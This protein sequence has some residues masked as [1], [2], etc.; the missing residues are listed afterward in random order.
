VAWH[1]H[2]CTIYDGNGQSQLTPL[3]LL[4]ILLQIGIEN[5][6]HNAGVEAQ[7]L[8]TLQ[9]LLIVRLLRL[10]AVLSAASRLIFF[11]FLDDSLR[12]VNSSTIDINFL[13]QD[14]AQ[15]EAHD[16]G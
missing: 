1:L 2:A 11:R 15:K 5:H 10:F 14:L 13:W 4:V 7:E 8:Q 9:I 6:V 3:G 12:G 16:L